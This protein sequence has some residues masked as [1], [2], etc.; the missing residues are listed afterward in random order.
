MKKYVIIIISVTIAIYAIYAVLTQKEKKS[1]VTPKP[2]VTA[3]VV[4]PVQKQAKPTYRPAVLSISAKTLY[5]DYQENEI[6]ADIKH[7]DKTYKISGTILNIGK[8]MLNTPYILLNT[9][10]RIG[11]VQCLFDP[12]HEH[13]LAN[14]SKNQRVVVKGK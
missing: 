6:A 12:D 5:T 1:Q 13:V 8:D 14:V 3:P 2:A 11:G 10:N 9:G 4:N 7:K